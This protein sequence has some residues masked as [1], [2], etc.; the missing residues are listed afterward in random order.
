MII[1]TPGWVTGKGYELLQ[2][3]IRLS[4]ANVV[5]VLDNDRLY[6]DLKKANQGQ[7]GL[8]IV[9]LPK[10]GGVSLS[11]RSREEAD[12]H[13]RL[14]QGQASSGGRQGTMQSASTS[15]GRSRICPPASS[16]FLGVRLPSI[17]LVEGSELPLQHFL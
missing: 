5:L 7:Q 15:T 6:N 11:S 9:K 1:N 4:R 3:T 14:Y 17:A 13:T 10:S 16:H 8:D 2:E 12:T